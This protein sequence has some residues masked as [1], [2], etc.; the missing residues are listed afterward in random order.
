MDKESWGGRNKQNGRG[1]MWM[2]LCEHGETNNGVGD[3]GKSG[4]GKYT[5]LDDAPGLAASQPLSSLFIGI[6]GLGN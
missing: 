5:M 1:R 3:D 4:F 2:K 6:T